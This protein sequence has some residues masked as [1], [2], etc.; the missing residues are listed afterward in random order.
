M[1][2]AKSIIQKLEEKLHHK[3]EKVK[4]YKERLENIERDKVD[5]DNKLVHIEDEFKD[6]EKNMK[7]KLLW[8]QMEK[9][10]LATTIL[11]LENSANTIHQIEL[12]HQD[13]CRPDRTLF[14]AK[15]RSSYSE[16]RI[17]E[18]RDQQRVDQ[19]RYSEGYQNRDLNEDNR[20]GSR[21]RTSL[22]RRQ[23]EQAN[24]HHFHERSKSVI[25]V[26]SNGVTRHVEFNLGNVPREDPEM[27]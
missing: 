10:D 7:L 5:I 3:D 25:S 21:N 6:K 20:S 17:V 23:I 12:N 15:R 4:K 11:K 9:K 22:R 24:P 18:S 16:E 13:E 27:R 8:A 19:N 1:D 2:E 14:E 26:D